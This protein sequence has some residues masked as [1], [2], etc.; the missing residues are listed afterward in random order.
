MR[1]I[2]INCYPHPL[3]H[4]TAV[5]TVALIFFNGCDNGTAQQKA[6]SA[7]KKTAPA[8]QK[9]ARQGNALMAPDFTLANLDGDWVT[10]NELKGKVV[11][12]ARKRRSER[13]KKEK[14]ED[15]LITAIYSI[16]DLAKEK[17]PWLT[18]P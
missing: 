13:R 14:P 1:R 16:S 3:R 11:L 17:R 8:V 12:L 5:A 15:G 9:N 6:E 7:K 2:I 18:T 10:L 4:I